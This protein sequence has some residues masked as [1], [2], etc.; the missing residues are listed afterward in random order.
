[1]NEWIFFSTGLIHDTDTLM[2][3]ALP[4]FTL[5]NPRYG[6]LQLKPC[7]FVL[8]YEEVLAGGAL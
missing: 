5:L 8:Q 6:F 3:E 1:M 4:Y 7:F 2:M